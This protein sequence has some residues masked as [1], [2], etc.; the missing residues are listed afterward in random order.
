[1]FVR[2]PTLN[3]QMQLRLRFIWSWKINGRLIRRD[4]WPFKMNME[5]GDSLTL[6]DSFF[7]PCRGLDHISLKCRSRNDPFAFIASPFLVKL[8][9]FVLLFT[10]VPRKSHFKRNLLVRRTHLIFP[11][12]WDGFWDGR[13][14]PIFVLSPRFPSRWNV[15]FYQFLLVRVGRRRLRVPILSRRTKPNLGLE[16]SKTTRWT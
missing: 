14:G 6:F 9:K 13:E 15:E 16:S 4:C 7:N 8:S 1:M 2:V 12:K 3:N 10:N 5:H 11:Q